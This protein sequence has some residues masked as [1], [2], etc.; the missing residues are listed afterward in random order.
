LLLV[1]DTG[2]LEGADA[3]P[4]VGNPESHAFLRQAVLGE[5]IAESL[6]EGVWIAELSPDDDA[7]GERFARDLE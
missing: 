3:N 7:R 2:D 1:L 5:E 6:G 4:V